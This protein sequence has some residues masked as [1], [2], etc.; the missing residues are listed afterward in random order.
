MNAR[1]LWSKILIIA[2]GI[3]MSVGAIDPMEGSL[4]IL[5]GSGLF[6][7][8]TYLGQAERRLITYRVTVF[9]LIAIGVA[10]LWGLSAVGGFGGTS[11]HSIWWGLLILPYVIG[12]LM[13]LW[14]PEN[15]RWFSLLGIVVG[16]NY[17]V[18]AGI[19][20]LHLRAGMEGWREPATVIIA[21]TG[22]AAIAGCIYRLRNRKASAM[23]RTVTT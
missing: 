8:G 6:A 9:I 12:W 17:L 11:G 13:A 15:P 23:A 21:T 22:I 20:V 19:F 1:N 2:G 14:G 16:L 10:A 18:V 7:L 5:P 4:L 3:G